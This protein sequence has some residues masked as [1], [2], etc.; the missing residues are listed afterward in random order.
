MNVDDCKYKLKKGLKQEKDYI[1]INQ[2]LWEWFS[3]NYNGGPELK[4]LSDK[5]YIPSSLAPIKENNELNHNEKMHDET[6]NN[7]NNQTGGLFGNTNNNQGNNNKNS[8]FNNNNTLFGNNTT[9]N[10][11]NQ[12]GGLFGNSTGGLFNN[13]N[14]TQNNNNSKNTG[15]LFGNNNNTSLFNNTNTT[16]NNTN[17]GGLFSTN[18]NSS[19]GGLFNQNNNNT[20]NSLFGNN[21]QTNNLN[22]NQN[23]TIYSDLTLEDIINPFGYLNSQKT[24]KLSP[25][26]EILSKTIIETIQKQK[27]VEEFLEDLDKKYKN[28]E[29]ADNNIDILESYGTYLS[30]TPDYDSGVIPLNRSLNV[31]NDLNDSLSNSYKLRNWN[32]TYNETSVYNKIDLSK[33]ISKIN[34]IYNEYERYKNNFNSEN[35]SMK[36]SQMKNYNNIINKKNIENGSFNKSLNTIYQNTNNYSINKSTS[37]NKNE[38]MANDEGLYQR[39]LIEFNKLSNYNITNDNEDENNE[40]EIIITNFHN[41]NNSSKRNGKYVD[42]DSLNGISKQMFNLK[43]KYNLPDEENTKNIHKIILENINKLVRIKSLRE[44]ISNRIHNELKLKDLD[45]YYSIER[46]SLLIPG[47]FLIDNKTLADYNLNDCNYNI[48]AYITYNSNNLKN[49]DFSQIKNNNLKKSYQEIKMKKEI[50]ISDSELVP[51]D[52]VPKLT[53]EGYNCSPSIM[54]LSRKTVYELRN[55]ENFKIF[56]K[57]GEVEFKEPV[58]LLGLNLDNQVTI[59]RNLID[60]G[61]KLN[62]KSVFKLFNFKVEENGLNRYK[63]NL[64][65]SGGNFLYYKNNELVWEYNG[66]I[67][68]KN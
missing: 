3:L 51:I 1:I 9:A 45:K 24:L 67:P 40:N 5:A 48:Q 2:H 41:E 33:S 22:K 49:K 37:V 7:N 29:K 68:V 16:S 43:I 58:N 23:T 6:K 13:N 61:D 64:K 26:D 54:E 50:Y 8:L 63:I 42:E 53:K 35:L 28:K 15:S 56:N 4:L 10:N 31:R 59:E 20:S 11:N 21:N 17:T 60:T 25:Q 34:E 18:N 44:E 66:D 55:I 36:N 39:N 30:S 12:T 27:S 57:Y 65:E 46:I 19:G 52:L 38:I 62:Y 47:V 32:K 14:N